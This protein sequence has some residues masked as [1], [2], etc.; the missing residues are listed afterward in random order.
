[1]SRLLVDL[2]ENFYDCSLESLATTVRS[3]NL[4][5]GDALSR[6]L[7]LQDFVELHETQFQNQLVDAGAE[8]PDAAPFFTRAGARFTHHLAPGSP[9]T[10]VRV[11]GPDGSYVDAL[12]PYGALR[13]AIGTPTLH[14]S[15]ELRALMLYSDRM[16]VIDPF[17][18]RRQ[19]SDVE[20]TA[21]QDDL[22]GDFLNPLGMVTLALG[23][24][25]QATAPLW[26]RP[27]DV[28]NS[29]ELLGNLAPLLRA[30]VV[31]VLPLPMREAVYWGEEDQLR[32]ALGAEIFS[33]L[34]G[35]I[36]Q[37]YRE[38]RLLAF[39]LLERAKD[40]LLSLAIY[41][42]DVCALASGD[43]D[44]IALRLQIDELARLTT[45]VSPGD[46]ARG[47]SRPDLWPDRSADDERLTELARLQLPG[48]ASLSARDMV[49]VREL[50]QF[51]G[52]RADIRR[53][54]ELSAAE[55]RIDDARS[56]LQEEMRGALSRLSARKT[57]VIG[58]TTAGDAVAWAV[59]AI[60]GWSIDG[61]RGS[62]AGLAGK[63]A[64]EVARS[65]S[66]QTKALRNHYIV[67]A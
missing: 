64:F 46:D 27:Y 21:L 65:R 3:P 43:L 36:G 13:G 33:R 61:W 42:D 2:L 58:G 38:A 56:A 17:T 57:S 37:R 1:M 11:V 35:S 62:L 8:F 23:S 45:P 22:G 24:R 49:S 39:V 59:G 31:T 40:Q 53:A 5:N 6:F 4:Q 9:P 18:A 67:V 12:D 14:D 28:A 48:V 30:D 20:W 19:F 32:H 16:A 60:V 15:K 26:D 63:A 34:P 54:L 41:G 66:S 25:Q 51:V 50:D 47:Y 52:F 7:R 10:G 55:P 29:L 44:T